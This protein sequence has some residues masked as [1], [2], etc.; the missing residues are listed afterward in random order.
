M[1]NPIPEDTSRDD[2]GGPLLQRAPALR[3]RLARVPL[4][5]FPSPV[6]LL[7]IGGRA[8]LVKRDDGCADGYAGNKVRKLEFLLGAARGL[9]ARRIITAGATGSHHALATALHGGRHGFAVTLVLFPQRLTPHVRQILLM[10]HGTGAELR[11]S[12]RL[13]LVPFGVWRAR[14]AHRGDAPYVVPP[15]GSNAVGT[16]G[17]V[18][19]GLELAA[20]VAAGEAARP[21]R[22]HVAAGTLG[23]VAGL[24]LGLAWAGLDVPVLATRITPRVVTNERVLRRLTEDTV[25]LLRS[26]VARPPAASAAL[27]LVELRHDQFGTGYGH[28]T[29]AGESATAIFA[30]AGLQLDQ[31]YTAKAAADLLSTAAAGDE[32][33]LFWHTLSAVEPHDLLTTADALPSPFAAYLERNG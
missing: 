17:Y 3:Q 7:T 33:P 15:G 27:R 12:R 26:L 16:L 14:R 32:L 22:I 9:G 13:E 11:W 23:T 18:N 25:A 6:Q 20:Q 24:S 10:S 4:G 8:V 5:T 21:T 28:A 19:A 31:T 30:E 29:A 1:S 2:A